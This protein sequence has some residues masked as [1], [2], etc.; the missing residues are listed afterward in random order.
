MRNLIG[1]A[2]LCGLG[3]GAASIAAQEGAPSMA[4]RSAVYAPNGV[5]ATSHPLATTAGLMVMERGGNAVDAAVTA[6]VMLNLVEPHMTGL[7]G[8]LFAL[9]WIEAEGRPVGLNA[10]GR[11]GSLMTR[12]AL[13]AGGY[14]AVPIHGAEPITVPGALS[15]WAALLERYGTIA[16]AEALEPT[17]RLA[18]RGFPV[19]PIIA[20][21]WAA[22]EEK[23]KSDEGARATY[24]VNGER[25]PR[26]GEWFRNPDL[27]STLRKIAARGPAELY[28]GELGRILVE[29]VRELG[30]FLTVEDLEDHAVQWV[31]TGSGSSRPT[32]RESRPWRCLEYWNRSTWGAWA[33]TRPPTSTT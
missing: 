5:I 14:E 29:R 8:D 4:G 23:L 19:S 3:L 13:L 16:L 11:S 17:I 30:G 22:E 33:T 27:A 21:Q 15:G 10:S 2:V 32:A 1:L 12:E 24:L 31:E 20:A 26:A 25:A 18:E 28:G 6:A 7:G 9:L